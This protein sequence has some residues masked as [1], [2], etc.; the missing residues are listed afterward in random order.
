[1]DGTQERIFKKADDD[2]LA[3]YL[4]AKRAWTKRRKTDPVVPRELIPLKDRDDPRP[5][6]Y[7][8]KRYADLFNSRQLLSLSLLGEAISQVRDPRAREFVATAF[9]DC[10]AANNMF[11]LFAFDYDKL[12]PLFGLHAYRRVS[13]PV[14]NNVWGVEYG[15]GSFLKCFRK[16]L[17][18][19]KYSSRPY[20]NSYRSSRRKV[21]TGETMERVVNW[22]LSPRRNGLP[23]AS[24]L[25]QSAENLRGVKSE[26]VDMILT[27]PPYYDNLPYSELSD[28][29]HVWLRRMRLKSY[30]SA[31]RHSPLSESLYVRRDHPKRRSKDHTNFVRR[32]SLAFSECRRV[33][34][35]SGMMIFTFHHNN[36]AAWVA[37][38]NALLAS[39]F[40]VTNAFPVLSE[41]HSQFHS[42]DGN[43]KW[44]FV[45]VC[46]K[47]AIR[48]SGSKAR[49]SNVL[50][51]AQ[52]DA[53]MWRR[54]LR[55][56][57][58]SLSEADLRSLWRG[59][60]VARL[61]RGRTRKIDLE[62]SLEL[63]RLRGD[64]K[65]VL[66]TP[67]SRMRR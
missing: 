24:I 38:A 54:K 48:R 42:A 52:R 43:L 15:R 46:R 29:F 30:P 4:R 60:I 18:A 3:L 63:P 40:V 47:R 16:L 59:F 7:G 39:G 26:S 50:L 22:K 65:S 57:G 28:F 11:C 13:R 19:K 6:V 23:Y 27:D 1:V 67:L 14:E 9:S 31:R 33:L 25:N 45:L 55:K 21:F 2:D 61:T 53:L 62:G 51:L 64:N 8:Y 35:S 41:G 20:E 10:L 37:V 36:P 5:I 49:G 58:F 12:T 66:S 32:L 17:R 44:D 56:A 34:K